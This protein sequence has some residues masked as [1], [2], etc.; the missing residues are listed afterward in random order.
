[1]W[2]GLFLE[3]YI[4]HNNVVGHITAGRHKVAASPQ[5]AAPKGLLNM[6]K[7]HHQLTRG[8]TFDI[9]HDLTRR[10]MRRTRQKHMDMILGHMA[11]QYLN[12]IGLT[13]LND[14]L[15]QPMPYIAVK[16]WLTVLCDPHK[17]ILYVKTTMGTRA[18]IFHSYSLT[19]NRFILKVSPKGEGFN[20]IVRH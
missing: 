11:T 18:I 20:P 6:A 8:L 16:H 17:M 1:M 7:L 12:L 13:Y 9:L 2:F 10:Q 19:D 14:Q 15:P 5:M 4:L 3:A